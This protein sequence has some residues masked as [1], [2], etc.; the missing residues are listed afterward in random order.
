MLQRLLQKKVGDYKK[1]NKI[2]AVSFEER[3]QKIMDEYNNR[4]ADPDYIKTLLDDVSNQ[5]L[6]LLAQLQEEENSFVKLNINYEEKAFYDIL[7]AVAE[8]FKFDYPEEQ[9]IELAKEIRA[10]LRDK[11]KYADWANSAQIKALMQADIIIILARHGYPPTPPEIY[12][13][14]YT[15]ILEQTENFKKY[16]DWVEACKKSSYPKCF[17]WFSF[18]I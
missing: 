7:V 3:L 16:S 2:K 14:V 4:M 13:K 5:L 8:K 9:N 11:E 6:D 17:F 18:I 1:I 12:E 15:D 10:A